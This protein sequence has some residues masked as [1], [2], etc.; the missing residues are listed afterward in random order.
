MGGGA[1][2]SDGD[3]I[4]SQAV[5]GPL[6]RVPAA[7]GTPTPLTVLDTT[8]R[9]LVHQWPVFLP[10]GRRFLYAAREDD[11]RFVVYAGSLDSQERTLVGRVGAAFTYAAPG[12]P[13]YLRGATLLAQRFDLDRLQLVGE[14][15]PVTEPVVLSD[16]HMPGTFWASGNGVLVYQ[17]RPLES[18]QFIWLDR[19]GRVVGTVGTPGTFRSF[20][21]SP[22]GQYVVVERIGS[23]PGHCDL[24][25]IDTERDVQTWPLL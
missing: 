22:D 20:A 9:Q 3:I 10:D 2:N 14:P 1:W 21:V 16:P 11:G 18:E 17:T 4:F 6:Y 13:L 12:H 8:V 7:G 23:E 24:W 25:V 15:V 5:F 19:T